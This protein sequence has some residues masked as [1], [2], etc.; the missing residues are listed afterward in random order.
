MFFI[1]H[2]H[3]AAYLQRSKVMKLRWGSDQM[4]DWGVSMQEAAEGGVHTQVEQKSM[5][6]LHIFISHMSC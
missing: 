4:H 1:S 3:L 2:L 5:L 6:K